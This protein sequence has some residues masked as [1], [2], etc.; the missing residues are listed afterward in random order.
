MFKTVYT[1]KSNESITPKFLQEILNLSRKNNARDGIRGFLVCRENFFLQLLEGQEQKVKEC[2][3]RI[4]K[5][6][7]HKNII[8]QAEFFSNEKITPGW[9]MAHLELN[10]KPWNAEEII[11]LFEM[12]RAEKVFSDS[13]AVK[14]MI[15]LFAQNA[16]VLG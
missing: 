10:E 8:I 7:R 1:S 15:K 12:A 14:T 5:D 11:S 16:K 13:G 9:G 2:M 3:D 4:K 6:S